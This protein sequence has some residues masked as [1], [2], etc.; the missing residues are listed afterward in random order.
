LKILNFLKMSTH[1]QQNKFFLNV[2]TPFV[3]KFE[4]FQ[5]IKFIS[6]LK[7]DLLRVS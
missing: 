7:V 1:V 2:P 5:F 4:V 3:F 6:I